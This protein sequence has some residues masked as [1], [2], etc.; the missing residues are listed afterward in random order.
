MISW[1]RSSTHHCQASILSTINRAI[2][3]YRGDIP[4]IEFV[5]NLKDGP[6]GDNQWALT[7]EEGVDR[8]TWIISDHGWWSWPVP[9]LGEYSA[10]RKQIAKQEPSWE[11]KKPLAAWRGVENLAPIREDLVKAAKDKE[12]SDIRSMT[13]AGN[14]GSGGAENKDDALT[15]LDHCNYKFLVYTEG[16][17]AKCQLN[18]RGLTKLS[19]ATYSGRF[20]YLHSCN[21]VIITHKLKWAEFHEPLMKYDGPDQ[22]IVR[23][24]R[25]WSDLDSTMKWLLKNPDIAQ[26][27]AANSAKTFRDRYLTPA[28]QACYTR[29]MIKVWSELQGFEPE[30]WQF[31]EDI[32]G[33]E[34]WKVRGT[35]FETW[36]IEPM[37]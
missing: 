22:N 15:A 21:S 29:R 27:I 20:K 12:W 24:E 36:L 2:T 6:S 8:T 17:L 14:G 9:L 16:T 26:R 28:A 18:I 32:N 4:N 10:I 1:A 11:D 34:V 25:D 37:V 23:V 5:L 19:G 7:R 35:P 3:A 31:K 13:W 30:L 33:H